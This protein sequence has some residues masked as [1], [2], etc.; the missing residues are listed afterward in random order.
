MNCV[1][2]QK[3]FADLLDHRRDER[4]RKVNDHLTACDRCTEELAALAA[5]QQLVSGLPPVEPPVGFTTRV[6]AEIRDTVHRPNT[7]QRLFLGTQKL[8]IQAAAVILISVLAVFIYQKES[9]QPEWTTTVPPASP[10]QKHDEADKLPAAAGGAPAPE[11]KV[12]ESSE[13][14]AQERRVKRSPQTEQLRSRAK[15]EEQSNIIG[16]VQP[17]VGKVAPPAASVN[18]A[19]VAPSEP[20]REASPADETG[21]VRQ[22]QSLRSGEAQAEGAPSSAPLR[23][24]PSSAGPEEK[25]ARSSFDA[26]SSGT[27]GFSDRKLILRVKQPARDDS[28]TER[29]SELE[30]PDAEASP[31]QIFKDLERGRQRAIQTGQPQTIAAIIDASQYDEFKKELARL[32]KIESEAPAP[33]NEIDVFSKSSGQ[34]RLTITVLPPNSSL[35]P[36]Q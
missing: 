26:L 14:G 1:E 2:A 20:K 19:K 9:R 4:L 5:C 24:S 22:E 13:A 29:L 6:M 8:P 15:P 35:Q 25:R 31:S 3:H 7:W 10:L 16:G 23:D 30:R 27:A 34:L 32:G 11:L 33:A 36:T 18:P 21:S 28:S 12:K 17:G